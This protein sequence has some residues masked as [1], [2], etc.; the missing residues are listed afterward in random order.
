MRRESSRKAPLPR[1]W[2][3]L[4]LEKLRLLATERGLSDADADAMPRIRYV[5][6]LWF[7]CVKSLWSSFVKFLWSSYVNSLWSSYVKSLWTSCVKSL[8]TS[9][10]KSLWSFYVK[11]LWSSFPLEKL[12]LLASERGLSDADASAMPRIRYVRQVY[13]TKVVD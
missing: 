2:A 4:P 10:V 11:S 13:L 1:D 6:S 3:S 8:W 12:R 9:Y 5:K 7:S